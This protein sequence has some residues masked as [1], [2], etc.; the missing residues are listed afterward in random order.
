M[1]VGITSLVSIA[2]NYDNDE[3]NFPL[4]NMKN[5]SLKKTEKRIY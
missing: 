3:Q 1:I 5:S 2:I 4:G